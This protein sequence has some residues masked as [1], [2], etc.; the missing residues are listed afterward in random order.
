MNP[1]FLVKYWRDRLCIP[2]EIEVE[3]VDPV[4]G[5]TNDS[6]I[7]EDNKKIH[8]VRNDD[9]AH[10]EKDIVRCFLEVQTDRNVL[11]AAMVRVRRDGVRGCL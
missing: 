9:R 8:I 11:A 10:M 7:S 6:C 2:D 5:S 4:E 3:L 1:K